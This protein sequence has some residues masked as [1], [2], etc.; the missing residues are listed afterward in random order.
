MQKIIAI[1]EGYVEWVA[2]A[3]GGVFLLFMVF[4]YLLTPPIKGTVNNR[5]VTLGDVDSYIYGAFGAPL[6]EKMRPPATV[7]AMPVPPYAGQFRKSMSQINNIGLSTPGP[8]IAL[9]V[10]AGRP[11]QAAFVSPDQAGIQ[12]TITARNLVNQ[13][14]DNLPAPKWFG[15]SWGRSTVVIPT[16]APA[17]GAV[18]AAGPSSNE[19]RLWVTEAFTVS[20]A[21]LDAVFAKAGIPK[22]QSTLFLRVEVTREELLPGPAWGNPK[23]IDPLAMHQVPVFPQ[24]GVANAEFAYLQW[25]NANA[26]TVLAPSFYPHAAGDQWFAPGQANPNQVT[27]PVVLPPQPVPQAPKVPVRPNPRTTPRRPGGGAT[28]APPDRLGAIDAKPVFAQVAPLLGDPAG[29]VVPAPTPAGVGQAAGAV[30]P[31]TIVPAGAFAPSDLTGDIFFWIHDDTVEPGKTYRYRADYRI[32][33]PMFLQIKAV[34]KQGLAQ[35]FSLVSPQSDWSTPVSIHDTTRFFVAAGVGPGVTAIKVNI[36]HWKGGKWN[37]KAFTISPG[38]QIGTL[39]NAVDY[40]TGWSLV[41]LKNDAVTREPVIVVDPGG[42]IGTRSY[43]GD[44]AFEGQFQKEIGWVNPVAPPK[45]PAPGSADV[46]MPPDMSPA[47]AGPFVGGRRPK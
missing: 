41:D 16:P 37:L 28:G 15:A 43:A 22:T 40:R 38:D 39:D 2:L 8:W 18:P 14:P 5:I 11:E 34:A 25:A 29:D 4:F 10:T 47:P 20:K 9:G 12:G 44:Q 35:Q 26:Q 23:T 45:V 31:G 6:E 33:N 42:R 13:L 30:P 32:K 17:A 21:D 24:G 19:D 36:Y 46:G 3:I 27:V 7:P 1:L